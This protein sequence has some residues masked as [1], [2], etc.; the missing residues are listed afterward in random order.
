[1]EANRFGLLMM[2]S[3]GRIQAHEGPGAGTELVRL[4]AQPLEHGHIEVAQRRRVIGI[5]RQVL[6]MLEA[7]TGKENRQVLG[8]MAASITEIAAEEHRR[9]VKQADAFLLR[10]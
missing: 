2:R 1:M 5:K 6:A 8:G 3:T 4:D 10:I 7:S 9:P